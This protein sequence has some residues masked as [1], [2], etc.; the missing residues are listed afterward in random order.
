MLSLKKQA[1]KEMD[2]KKIIAHLCF[3]PFLNLTTILL[4]VWSVRWQ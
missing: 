2:K 4:F 3:P 1:Q